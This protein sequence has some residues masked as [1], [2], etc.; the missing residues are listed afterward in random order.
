MLLNVSYYEDGIKIIILQ[1]RMDIVGTQEI[2]T[3]FTALVASETSK[4]IIDLL[5]FEFMSSIGIGIIVR[6]ADALLR[7]GGKI[8]ILNPRVEVLRVLES[9]QITKVIPVF[10][11]IGSAAAYFKG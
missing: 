11:D 4:I 5:G 7:R 1:G 2:E 8:V 10:N 6:V 3:R 9:T